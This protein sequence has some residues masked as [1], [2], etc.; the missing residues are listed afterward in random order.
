M[1]TT[2]DL[3][4]LQPCKDGLRFAKQFSTLQE[5]WNKC[6]HSGWMWWF[7]QNTNRTP[8]ELSIKYSRLCAD[9]VAYL[10]SCTSASYAASAYA[11]ASATAASYASAYA[12][13]SERKWQADQLRILVP[14]I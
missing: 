1:K 4:T 3:E 11:S 8:K 6:E 5:A 12:D 2:K 10:N 9:H 13:E 7:L 14:T